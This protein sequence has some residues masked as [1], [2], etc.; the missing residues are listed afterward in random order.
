MPPCWRHRMVHSTGEKLLWYQKKVLEIQ[1]PVCQGKLFTRP[2]F[3]LGSATEPGQGEAEGSC[4]LLGAAGGPLGGSWYWRSC[5]ATAKPAGKHIR[6]TRKPFP[7]TPLKCRVGNCKGLSPPHS[8]KQTGTKCQNKL[9]ENSGK[10]SQRLLQPGKHLIK[11]KATISVGELCG[12]SINPGFIPPSQAWQHP[13]NQ[14]PVF[15][16]WVCGAGG[17]RA[18]FALK[19]WWVFFFNLSG[20]SVKDRNRELVFISQNWEHSQ[21]RVEATQGNLP[22]MFKGKCVGLCYLRQGMTFETNKRHTK[23]LGRKADKWGILEKK[24][25][26]ILS[27]TPGNLEGR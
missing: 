20:G 21:D 1:F 8:S 15:P 14:P 23:K 10:E 22:K 11:K 6:T 26:E 13:W 27:Q 19:E 7:G 2:M 16:V 5:S 3:A 25:F 12:I 17:S 18:D 9:Y 4:R 24:G